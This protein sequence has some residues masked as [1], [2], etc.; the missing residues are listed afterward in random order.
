MKKVLLIAL[1]FS[2]IQLNAQVLFKQQPVLSQE[3]IN[4]AAKQFTPL[5][6][7][8]KKSSPKS[9]LSV[10][11][12]IN[13]VKKLGKQ[14]PNQVNWAQSH[15]SIFVGVVPHDTLRITGNWHHN[16]PILV[17]NDGVLIFKNASVIDSG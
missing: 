3:K 13:E 2:L 1:L 9:V 16:G 6:T 14:N 7:D 5:T 10:L 11:K 15:D 17:L 12:Q 4:A 8:A